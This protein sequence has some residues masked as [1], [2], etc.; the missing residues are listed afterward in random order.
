[1][2]VDDAPV[3]V[4][5]AIAVGMNAIRHRDAEDTRAAL[6][7]LIPSLRKVAP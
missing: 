3:N 5:A 2:F 6:A 4:E 7:A 1:V